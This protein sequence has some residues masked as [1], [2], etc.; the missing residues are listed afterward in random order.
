ML[1]ISLLRRFSI[2]VPLVALPMIIFSANGQAGPYLDSGHGG[3][4]AANK[5]VRRVPGYADGNCA[6][7][8][9]QH[10]SINGAEPDPVKPGPSDHLLFTELTNND[11][12]NYCHD[13]NELNSAPN[14]AS[15]IAKPFSHDPN[16]SKGPVLCGDCHNSHV[17]QPGTHIAPGNSVL[18]ASGSGV[19]LSVSGVSVSWSGPLSP[20]VGGGENL[21]PDPTPTTIPAITMEY[22]LCLKCHGGQGIPYNNLEN[23]ARQFNPG[24]YSRH[25][26]TI[27]PPPVTGI[28]LIYHLEWA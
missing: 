8:H 1:T 15:Q 9:E 10:A 16:S 7:C 23:I 17:A 26:V 14:I 3:Y 12:C 20:P 27:S 6:H 19:L 18:G 4:G 13:I 21:N 22:Q 2:I 24:N 28:T 25:P 5:G 11:L